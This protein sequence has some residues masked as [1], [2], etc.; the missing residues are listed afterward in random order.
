MG[1][2]KQSFVEADLAETIK[3]CLGSVATPPLLSADENKKLGQLHSA[4]IPF[5]VI[6]HR[7][8]EET[9]AGSL[10]IQSMASDAVQ[11]F[12]LLIGGFKKSIA[13]SFRGILES[14]LRYIYYIDHPIEYRKLVCAPFDYMKWSDLLDY[15]SSHP[16]LL[17]Y[18]ANHDAIAEAKGMY[19]TLSKYVHGQSPDYS[20][21]NSYIVDY[22]YTPE[23]LEW[24]LPLARSVAQSTVY[25]LLALSTRML[26]KAPGEERRAVLGVLDA[27][28]KGALSRLRD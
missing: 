22:K 26:E 21:I 17:P 25:L 27:T 2:S 12:P 24:V 16:D 3:M 23:L 13:L 19:S 10:F 14:A 20:D 28:Q 6:R 1:S 15:A 4:L 9:D 5:V 18:L 11:V 7:S 8:R